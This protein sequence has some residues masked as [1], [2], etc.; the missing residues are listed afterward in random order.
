VSRGTLDTCVTC[1]AGIT[2]FSGNSPA[3]IRVAGTAAMRLAFV[4]SLLR[5]T[6]T[7]DKAAP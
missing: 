3:M 7:P 6:A 1:I 2:V 5:M 4:A